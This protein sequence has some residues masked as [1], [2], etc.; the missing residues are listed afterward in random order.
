[1]GGRDLANSN[2]MS[3][4]GCDVIFITRA[5]GRYKMFLR[6]VLAHVDQATILTAI[7]VRDGTRRIAKTIMIAISIDLLAV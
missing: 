2:T 4:D 6:I 7:C 5:T 1:M 3:T